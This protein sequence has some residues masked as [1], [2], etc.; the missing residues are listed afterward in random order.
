MV[1]VVTVVISPQYCIQIHIYKNTA[2]LRETQHCII[3]PNTSN[4]NPVYNNCKLLTSRHRQTF[5][6]LT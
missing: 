1:V 5:C 3:S 2:T 4:Y 6:K